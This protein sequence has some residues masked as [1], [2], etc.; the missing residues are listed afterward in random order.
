MSEDIEYR[1]IPTRDGT[2]FKGICEKCKRPI[3]HGGDHAEDC[4]Y[5]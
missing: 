5:G 3:Y 1:S 4:I 2:P